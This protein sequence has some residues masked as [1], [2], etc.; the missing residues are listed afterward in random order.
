M[1]LRAKQS[2]PY[3]WLQI[4]EKHR[5]NDRVRQRVWAILSPTAPRHVG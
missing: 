3:E 1:F 4:V 2:G 5:D